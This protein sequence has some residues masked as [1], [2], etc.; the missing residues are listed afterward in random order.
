MRAMEVISKVRMRVAFTCLGSM[1][2]IACTDSGCLVADQITKIRELQLDGQTYGLYIRTAG[3][4]EKLHYYELYRGLPEFDECGVT[5]ASL[6]SGDLVGDLQIR[7][8]KLLVDDLKLS[9]VFPEVGE[10]ATFSDLVNVPVD[11]GE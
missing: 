5:S 11:V 3:M 2:L 10:P 1:L 8:E 4:H 9:V 7:P 6:V